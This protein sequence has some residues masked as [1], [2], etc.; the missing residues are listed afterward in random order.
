MDEVSLFSAVWRIIPLYLLL[1]FV[2]IIWDVAS[3]PHR[4]RRGPNT[5]IYFVDKE[6]LAFSKYGVFSTLNHYL[7]TGHSIAPDAEFL[8]KYGDQFM[9]DLET[10]L[11]DKNYPMG[12]LILSQPVIEELQSL[13]NKAHIGMAANKLLVQI[14]E[15]LLKRPSHVE[16]LPVDKDFM[17]S[18][19][20]DVGSHVEQLIQPLVK[21]QKFRLHTLVFLT[22]DS[23]KRNRGERYGLTLHQFTS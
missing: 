14:E 8:L 9:Y 5:T 21:A 15:G 10:F 17:R 1:L 6:R 22:Q 23:E 11:N 4:P 16:V 18:T 3:G 20:M 13:R 7:C 19:G 12:K 2:T